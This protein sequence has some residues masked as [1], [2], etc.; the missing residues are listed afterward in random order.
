MKFVNKKTRCNSLSVILEKGNIFCKVLPFYHHTLDPW[1]LFRCLK[2]HCKCRCPT[3]IFFFH[4]KL[5]RF[6]WPWYLPQPPASSSSWC[7]TS[8]NDCLHSSTVSWKVKC[9][10]MNQTTELTTKPSLF[11][12]LCWSPACERGLPEL[13]PTLSNSNATRRKV[14]RLSKRFYKRK[15]ISVNYCLKILTCVA[16]SQRCSCF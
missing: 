8:F 16:E 5:W 2:L 11:K 13:G 9:T 7:S 6:H 15:E 10:Q 14:S 1:P 12:S 3:S 4:K